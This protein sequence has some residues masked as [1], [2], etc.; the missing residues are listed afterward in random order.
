MEGIKHLQPLLDLWIRGKDE[1]IIKSYSDYMLYAYSINPLSFLMIAQKQ[2][3]FT[4][5]EKEIEEAFQ[6]AWNSIKM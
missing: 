2:Y 4:L 3:D 6:A 1:G 5:G